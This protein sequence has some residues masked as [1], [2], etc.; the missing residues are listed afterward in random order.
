MAPERKTNK[1]KVITNE[2]SVQAT[3]RRL[4]RVGNGWRVNHRGRV[5]TP[6]LHGSR[7]VVSLRRHG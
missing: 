7:G 4:T 1:V 6:E 3:R 5:I 2:S